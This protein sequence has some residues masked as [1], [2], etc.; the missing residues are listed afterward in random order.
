M[1]LNC[2]FNLPNYSVR[3]PFAS[4]SPVKSF[5][6]KR[7]PISP[8]YICVF[9]FSSLE[10]FLFC[11]ANSFCSYVEKLFAKVSSVLAPPNGNWAEDKAGQN[12]E[13]VLDFFK[14]RLQIVRRSHYTCNGGRHGMCNSTAASV[15]CFTFGCTS[16]LSHSKN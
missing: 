15:D 7:F 13:E 14:R 8:I 3:S 9:L 1:K 4:T 11:E 2:Q 5:P 6:Y 12:M 16:S 10:I